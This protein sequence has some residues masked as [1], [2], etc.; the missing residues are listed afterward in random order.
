[1]P[2][3]PNRCDNASSSGGSAGSAEDADAGESSGTTPA[4][5]GTGNLGHGGA[6]S[7]AGHGAGGGAT[8]GRSGSA[9]AEPEGG[10]AGEDGDSGLGFVVSATSVCSD[11]RSELSLTG[12]RGT[13]PYHF[14]LVAG[15]AGVALVNSADGA[16]VSGTF[17]TPGSFTLEVRVTDAEQHSATKPVNLHVKQTPV[18]TTTS[19]PDVCPDEMYTARLTATGDAARYAYHVAGLD[20]T[21]LALSDDVI[22]GHFLNATGKAGKLDVNVSV[23]SD[24]CVSPPTTLTLRETPAGASAC[25]QIALIGGDPALPLPCAGN[26]YGVSF[27]A[28]GGTPGYV[29]DASLPQGL[30]FDAGTQSV[31]GIPQTARATTL[32]VRVTD[33]GK[34]TIARD[35]PLGAPRDKCWFAYLA[36]PTGTTQLNLLDPLLGNRRAFPS[37][38][39]AEP[40]LDF[41]FSPDGHLL[42]YRTGTDPNAGRLA[43]LELSTFREQ[44]FDFEAVRHYTWSADSHTLVVGFGPEQARRLGGVDTSGDGGAGAGLAFPELTSVPAEVDSEPVWYAGSRLA[45]F[46]G[47]GYRDVNTTSFSAGGF[48]TVTD[49][50]EDAFDDGARLLPGPDG[51][52][53][54]PSNQFNVDFIPADGSSFILHDRVLVQ[55]TGELTARQEPVTDP[56]SNEELGELELFRARTDSAAGF[57]GI[58]DATAAGCDALLGWA[59]SGDRV[60]CSHAR[61]DDAARSEL[62]VFEL[63][64]DTLAVSQPITVRNDYDFPRPGLTGLA[65]LFSPSGKRLA[66]ATD[67]HLYST[68]TARGGATVDLAWTFYGAPGGANAVLAF[69][70]DERFLLEHRGSK[71]GLFDLQ[72]PEDP[73]PPFGT[74]DEFAPAPACSEDYHA[75]RGTYCGELRARS[76][77][78][79]SPASWLPG[80]LLVALSTADGTL[81]VRNL[82]VLD[83]ITTTTATDDCGQGCVAEDRFA[84]QP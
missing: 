81:L 41:K 69:S 5:G 65:R 34:R 2:S 33:D 61:A 20:G 63:D 46:T 42:A 23:E 83:R 31:S 11:V 72:H 47:S 9:G 82:Q 71:L 84:F 10:A 32:T 54:I 25:P 48:S 14:E 3:S 60:L 36:P 78:T 62:V 37:G 73:P 77:F 8:A 59:G 38:T 28:Y 40:A 4:A 70:P 56:L 50:F 52:F 79:W 49:R 76:A 39:G 57:P 66:F 12:K 26:D 22:L 44:V 7:H 18:L 24:G 58:P 75:A 43:L 17:A 53:A 67:D 19:L 80:P 74:G 64:S 21:D 45:F 13:P 15:P 1:M 16:V 29:W 55:P 35:F 30:T 6:T 27:T 68:P 51:V